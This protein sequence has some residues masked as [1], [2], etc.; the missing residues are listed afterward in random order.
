MYKNKISIIIPVYNAEKYIKQCLNSIITQTI[1]DIEIIC[2]DDCST[3]NSLKIL[4][5]YALKDNRIKIIEQKVNQGQGVG[6]N[7]A[8]KIT[9][10]EYIGFVDPDDW[11]EPN[12]YK[13]MYNKAKEF[14]TDIVTCN[15]ERFFENSSQV[16][17]IDTIKKI[18]KIDKTI[19]S[20]VVFN[21]KKT[22]KEFLA[23]TNNFAWCR[24]YRRELVTKYDIRFAPIRTGED[25]LFCC[26]AKLLAD[27]IIHIDKE[28]YHY[29]AHR[30]KQFIK[31]E[32]QDIMCL[33]LINEIYLHNPSKEIKEGIIDFL[34][35]MCTNQYKQLTT[36]ER[37]KFYRDCTNYLPYNSFKK[38]K[39]NVKRIH[40]KQIIHYIFSTRKII[41]NGAIYKYIYILGFKLEIKTKRDNK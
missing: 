25:K 18:S 3:D 21:F 32:H 28:F 34:S 27:K 23:R 26:L 29:R 35:I 16:D 5:E 31:N 6:R 41:K 14:D 33:S 10:G 22:E 13:E 20:G 15:I 9:E 38:F 30:T 17:H 19:K 4:K 39:K 36:A 24:I 40:F 11:I 7:E 37:K 2:I 8:I 12:M 1:H